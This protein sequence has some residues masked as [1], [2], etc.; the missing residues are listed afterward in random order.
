M[1]GQLLKEFREYYLRFEALWTNLMKRDQAQKKFKHYYDKMEV[2]NK[3]L[4][5]KENLISQPGGVGRPV[6]VLNQKDRAKYDRNEKKYQTS[7][8]D[9]QRQNKACYEEG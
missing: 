1:Q 2:L 8:N 4:K 5:Q 6:D 9:F 3:D 7:L